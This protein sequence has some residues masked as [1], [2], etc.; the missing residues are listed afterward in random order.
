MRI[1]SEK[2]LWHEEIVALEG[3]LEKKNYD[4]E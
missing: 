3:E 4:A 2:D 1:S